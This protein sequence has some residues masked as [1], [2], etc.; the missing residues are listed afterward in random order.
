MFE[1][2]IFPYIS[3]MRF[4]LRHHLGG[5]IVD[6]V[7]FY[8]LCYGFYSRLSFPNY[9][10][11]LLSLWDSEC[12]NCA[13]LCLFNF[14]GSMSSNDVCDSQILFFYYM[15]ITTISRENIEYFFV[16]FWI[17]SFS[18]LS[19]PTKD[20]EFSLHCCLIHSWVYG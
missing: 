9:V 18:S 4:C 19:L 13:V 11:V 17:Q 6:I 8:F 5:Q 3:S 15:T 7:K 12:F 14:Q 16:S 10:G 20:R 2:I 1:A